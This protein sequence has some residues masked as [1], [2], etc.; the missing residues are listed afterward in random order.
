[1]MTIKMQ[2]FLR[3]AFTAGLVLSALSLPAAH[4]DSSDIP[5]NPMVDPQG[6]PMTS[7]GLNRAQETT[8]FQN[9]GAFV[10]SSTGS[11]HPGNCHLAPMSHQHF[12]CSIA[13]EIHYAMYPDQR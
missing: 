11:Q 5:E 7:T 6:P 9:L 8:V 1:M 12:F 13:S 10:F 3:T 2:R 4:A